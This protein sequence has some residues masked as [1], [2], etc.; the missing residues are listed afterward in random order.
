MND[1]VRPDLEPIEKA[2]ERLGVSSVFGEP[3]KEGDVTVVPVAEVRFALGYG[4]G[5]GRERSEAGEGG[6]GSSEGSGGGSGAGGRASPKGY[7]R[8]SPEG[9]RFEPVVDVTRIALAGMAFAAWTVFWIG[10]ALRDAH[11]GR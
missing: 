7:I 1:D 9:V 11:R 4:H 3:V 8:I 10:R 5:F 2:V 6:P